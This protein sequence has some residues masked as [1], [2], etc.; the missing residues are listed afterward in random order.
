MY[1]EQ[2]EHVAHPDKLD[3]MDPVD[4]LALGDSLASLATLETL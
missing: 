1:R 4:Q 2:K 3:L